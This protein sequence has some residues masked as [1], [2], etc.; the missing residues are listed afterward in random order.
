MMPSC[1]AQSC[2]HTP[3][4]LFF[5]HRSATIANPAQH[6]RRLV[7]LPEPL[8]HLA[9]ACPHAPAAGHGPAT[10]ARALVPGSN[11]HAGGAQPNSSA[12]GDNAVGGV[13]DGGSSNSLILVDDDGSPC[14]PKTF[15]LWN[16]PLCAAA[17]RQVVTSSAQQGAGALGPAAADPAQ[18]PS[19]DDAESAST[20]GSSGQRVGAAHELATAPGPATAPAPAPEPRLTRK[21]MRTAARALLRDAQAARRH[22]GADLLGAAR[23]AA[24]V[25]EQGMQQGG[26]SAAGTQAAASG[27]ASACDPAPAQPPVPPPGTKSGAWDTSGAAL[28]LAVN[29]LKARVFGRPSLSQP[30][31]LGSGPSSTALPDPPGALHQPQQAHLPEPFQTSLQILDSTDLGAAAG[32]APAPPPAPDPFLLTRARA[33]LSAVQLPGAGSSRAPATGR[34]TQNGVGC[35]LVCGSSG[36]GGGCE[37]LD[38]RPVITVGRVWDL[39]A[40]GGQKAAGTGVR[41]GATAPLPTQ[42]AARKNQEAGGCTVQS[43]SQQPGAH[44][45]S[46]Q[47]TVQR[48]PATAATATAKLSGG[49]VANDDAAALGV[50]S[51]MPSR[52]AWKEVHGAAGTPTEARRD[53]PI[54]EVALLL[55]ECVQHGLRTI[56]FCKVVTHVT[57]VT[58]SKLVVPNIAAPC[59]LLSPSPFDP[60]RL[61]LD[62]LIHAGF[63]S[64]SFESFPI[65]L[66]PLIVASPLDHL[67]AV[68]RLLRACSL[69]PYLFRRSA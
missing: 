35:G 22:A 67:P 31:P 20:H 8:P 45:K 43:I 1:S 46:Q 25:A 27:P 51:R 69:P 38:V 56:T 4:T 58:G 24:A 32:P 48:G 68:C 33:A 3:F 52:G 44:R 5:V 62:P 40:V 65:D 47:P 6:A 26:F 10:S 39:A 16:P 30:H 7:G 28:A 21:A 42:P 61:P 41:A 15:V 34:H 53:S 11:G 57:Y 12:A 55:A 59:L 64:R 66:D 13:W 63:D 23:E 29:R 37:E 60:C 54:V 50:A 19:A 18:A 17:R 14:G 36:S 2:A 9:P 49:N